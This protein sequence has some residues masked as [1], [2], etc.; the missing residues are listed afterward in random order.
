MQ[1]GATGPYLRSRKGWRA[2]GIDRSL[3]VL[4]AAQKAL[5]KEGL[6][7]ALSA[8]MLDCCRSSRTSFS[9]RFLT[10]NPAL[11]RARCRALHRGD[12]RVSCTMAVLPKSKWPIKED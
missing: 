4:L 2:I 7:A 1:L 11:L 6:D 12:W 5:G 8:V 10:V 3:G 9:A